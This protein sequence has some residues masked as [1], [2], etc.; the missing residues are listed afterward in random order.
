MVIVAVKGFGI[1]IV[2]AG[3]VVNVVKA[4]R[5]MAAHIAKGSTHSRISS[6]LSRLHS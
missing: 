1:V 2:T 4:R 3:V 6:S 5:I